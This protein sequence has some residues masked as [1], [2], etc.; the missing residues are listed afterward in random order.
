MRPQAPPIASLGSSDITQTANTFRQGQRRA[1]ACSQS[2]VPLPGPQKDAEAPSPSTGAPLLPTALLPLGHT[3]TESLGL[4]N[5]VAAGLRAPRG[6]AGSAP[7]APQTAYRQ[8]SCTQ[9]WGACTGTA[10]PRWERL[11]RDTNRRARVS[12][13]RRLSPAD[14]V[15]TRPESQVCGILRPCL[16]PTATQWGGEARGPGAEQKSGAIYR[17]CL[18][19]LWRGIGPAGESKTSPH[20]C[21]LKK[22]LGNNLWIPHF[23][24]WEVSAPPLPCIC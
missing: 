11:S 2:S 10:A 23:G 1:C 9:G 6:S 16:P 17:E 5:D 18:S 14:S 3:T 21:L 15:R 7:R 4:G 24:R 20:P 19:L 13:V 12:T 22:V 8:S